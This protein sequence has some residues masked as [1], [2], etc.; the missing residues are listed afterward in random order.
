MSCGRTCEV[1]VSALLKQI[2]RLKLHTTNAMI[3]R[4][5]P[6]FCSSLKL[7]SN[8]RKG[9]MNTEMGLGSLCL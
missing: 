3:L 6:F 8:V 9:T 4:A 7:P 1:W 5:P 2:I